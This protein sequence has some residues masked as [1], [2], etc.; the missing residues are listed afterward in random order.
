MGLKVAA[1]QTETNGDKKQNIERALRQLE[2]AAREGV[3]LCCLHEYLTAEMPEKGKTSEDLM[4]V[5]ERI[6]GPTIDVLMRKAKE[7]SIYLVAGSIIEVEGGKLY[8][9]SVLISPKGEMVGKYRKMHPEDVDVKYEI[10]CGITPGEGYPVFETEVGKI[11]I[12]VDMDATVPVVGEIYALQ[13]AEIICWPVNWSVRVANSFR[14]FSLSNALV[15]KCHM[16]CANRVGIRKNSPAGDMYYAGESRI[17]DPEGNII[18][19]TRDYYEGAA[20]ATIDVE[21]TRRFRKNT[22]VDYPVRR[23]PET[24][25]LIVDREAV[26]KAYGI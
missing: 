17:T 5:A 2:G 7:L 20:I 1:I 18:G 19:S 26:R 16:I 4:K 6:P 23:R 24:Y 8:N 9:T 25:R 22:K 11:G 15:S 12:M 21:Y 14:A 10:S 3:K 13:G